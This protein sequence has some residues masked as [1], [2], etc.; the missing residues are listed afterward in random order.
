M[1]A[2]ARLMVLVAFGAG[3][4]PALAGAKS[5]PPRD[6]PAAPPSITSLASAPDEDRQLREDLIGARDTLQRERSKFRLLLPSIVLA[7]GVALLLTSVVAP[8]VGLLR[9]GSFLMGS[10]FTGMGGWL[11]WYTVTSNAEMDERIRRLDAEIGLLSRGDD[12]RRDRRFV[13]RVTFRF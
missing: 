4:L 9:F 6:K 1:R 3:A 5:P 2:A 10:M 8:D 7:G 12:P 11:V 13:A